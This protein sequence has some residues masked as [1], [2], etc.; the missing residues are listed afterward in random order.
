MRRESI[1]MALDLA[2]R[3]E[4]TRRGFGVSFYVC[5]CGR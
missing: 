1:L 4:R 3:E 5:V 2:V